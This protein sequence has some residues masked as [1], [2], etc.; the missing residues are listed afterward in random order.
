M[1]MVS[2]ITVAN[3]NFCLDDNRSIRD[4]NQESHEMTWLFNDLLTDFFVYLNNSAFHVETV[5][6]ILKLYVVSGTIY[7]NASPS[8]LEPQMISD[9]Q[10]K[11]DLANAMSNYCSFFNFD[12]LEK[13]IKSI[14][15][16]NGIVRMNE[17]K[18]RFQQY[19]ENRVVACMPCNVGVKDQQVTTLKF[20]LDDSFKNCN[21]KFLE[22]LKKEASK[23]LMVNPDNMVF[24]CIANASVVIMFHVDK[25]LKYTIFPLS[26]GQVML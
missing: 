6:F 14:E 1:K 16:E 7:R 4:L 19:L 26:P 18:K 24:D 8:N 17:Y 22:H 25:L 12:L 10:N 13:A 15:F 2:T 3:T 21:A 23:I 5:K 11:T 20:R 9:I